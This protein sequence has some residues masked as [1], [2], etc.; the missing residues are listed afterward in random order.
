[1]KSASLLFISFILFSACTPPSTVL[2]TATPL[3]S[4]EPASVP[5]ELG[6]APTYTHPTLG[7]TLK[8]P[9]DL[10]VEP[11]AD[12]SIQIRST[13]E[14]PAVGPANF[15]YLSVI[16]AGDQSPQGEIYNYNPT[17]YDKLMTLSIGEKISLADLG[18]GQAEWFSYTRVDDTQIDGRMVRRFENTKPWEF[19]SGTTEVRYLFEVNGTRYLLG[20]Y[21][22]GEGVGPS[23]LDPRLTHT[24][25]T[26]FKPKL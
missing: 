16:P 24:V 17:D 19:P 23:S 1:M 13:Q 12:Y 7:Y 18:G 26:S 4:T 15:M 14:P 25:L 3:A 10:V 11:V 6:N 2:S 22:G 5:A 9:T 20:A 21:T 8:V